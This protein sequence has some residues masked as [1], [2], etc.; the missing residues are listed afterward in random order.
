MAT[1]IDLIQHGEGGLSVR[2]KLNDLI[3]AANRGALG[4]FTRDEFEDKFDTVA[5]A[6]PTGL[7]LSSVTNPESALIATWNTNIEADFLYY[8]VQVSRDGGPF[9]GVATAVPRVRVA[10]PGGTE[11]SVIVAAVDRAGNVSPYTDPVTYT[12]DVDDIPPAMPIGFNAEGGFGVIWLTWIGNSEA[13]LAYY[14]V[15]ESTAPTPSPDANTEPSFRTFAS[16]YPRAGLAEGVTR[17]YFVRA[18]D[19]AGN[20]S[21]WSAVASATTLTTGELVVGDDDL[22]AILDQVTENL[23]S[24]AAER[25]ERIA[26]ARSLADRM[27]QFADQ[28]NAAA[29]RLNES[30]LTTKLESAG[31]R[32][33]IVVGDE[34]VTARFLEEIEVAIGPDSAIA[35]RF[36]A[37]E[38]ELDTEV[39]TLNASLETLESAY[40]TADAAEAAEREALAAQLRGTYEGT[41]IESVTAG[42]IYSER[43]A[44]ADA[45]GAIASSVSALS[46]SVADT[47][48]DLLTEQQ[49]RA[50]GDEAEAT[51]REALS[52]VVVGQADPTGL[53]LASLSAGLVYSERVARSA[54]D[55]AL[56]SQIDAVQ[57]ELT[58]AVADISA[59][60]TAQNA[61]TSTVETLEDGVAANAANISD[62]FAQLADKASAA[63][64]SALESTVTDQGGTLT[65]LSSA[66]DAVET[67]LAG[68]ASSAALSSLESTVSDLGDT[69]TA[70]GSAISAVEAGLAD[71]ADSSAL[72]ALGATVSDLGDTVEAQGT[73]LTSLQ[74]EVDEKASASALSALET[75]VSDQGD[76]ISSQGSAIT[77]LQSDLATLDDEV[78]TKADA[79]ALSSLSATVADQGDEITSLGA[80]VTSIQADIETIEGDLAGKASQSALTALTGRVD[81]A[82]DSITAQ[83]TAIT[84]LQSSLGG[85]A[86]AFTA[87]RSWEFETGEDGWTGVNSTLS[88][89]D[90]IL[91]QTA[92]N[93][94]NGVSRLGLNVNGTLYDKVRARVRRTSGSGVWQGQCMYET[95]G[96]GFLSTHM[97][98]IDEPADPAAW[99][100]IEFDMTNL[101]AGGT[102]WQTSTIIGLRLDLWGN[103]DVVEFDWIAVGKHGA[104]VEASAIETLTSEVAN[105]DGDVVAQAASVSALQAA[106]SGYTGSGAVASAIDS[107]EVSVSDLDGE[108]TAQATAVQSLFTSLGGDTAEARVSWDV[109]SGPS[110]F[111]RYELIGRTDTG[112]ARQASFVMDVPASVDDPSQITFTSDHFKITDGVTTVVP[113]R[114]DD[115]SVYIDDLIVNTSNLDFD[116]VTGKDSETGDIT[117]AA[118]PTANVV[119]PTVGYDIYIDTPKVVLLR[120]F[121]LLRAVRSSGTAGIG[122]AV[123]ITNQTSGQVLYTSTVNLTSGNYQNQVDVFL[124][125]INPVSGVNQYRLSVGTIRTGT[126]TA[127]W[128]FEELNAVPMFQ[129]LWWKR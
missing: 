12:T 116:A 63:A 60:S 68:K 54:A 94:N 76:T 80:A 70:Q 117:A 84:A 127:T 113:F 40:T 92:T 32:R 105:L 78:E 66:V 26:S 109:V 88:A 62:A 99:S 103:S 35:Q 28:V 25:V 30:I 125:D 19:R 73:A 91:E 16:A 44:R 21:P 59:L 37:L 56:S 17:H 58:D 112:I 1:D 49:A 77:A 67:E 87:Y 85:A 122:M 33:E 10:M 39:A 15:L 31:I 124:M 34:G 123:I 110:G 96:H 45:D 23:E 72:S 61:L 83:G 119:H 48:A 69:V 71:K 2:T 3:D 101:T 46:A 75:T 41:D 27:R 79:S 9:E 82:E 108:L 102:D 118:P 97:K 55:S 129:T 53:D 120:C 24:I 121:G 111:V 52:T 74:S 107:L 57:S 86:A 65:A 7:V 36:T 50:D 114:I 89:A 100:V 42:L 13:D 5:P 4:A 14:E 20:R 93:A 128:E 98:V 95:A 64:V 106:L 51:A 104:G 8:D 6:K 11:V 22:N 47:Q 29:L 43:V 38:T 18:V 126:V 81:T 115:G 90:G